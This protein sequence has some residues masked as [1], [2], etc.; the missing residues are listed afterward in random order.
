MWPARDVGRLA[1]S[2]T[3]LLVLSGPIL[4]PPV[5]YSAMAASAGVAQAHVTALLPAAYA[6]GSLLTSVPAACFMERFGLRC[7][8]VVGAALQAVFATAQ[9][10]SE[11]LWQLVALQAALGACHGFAGTVGFI[12]FCNA[13][14]GDRPSTAIAIQFSAFGLAA[15]SKCPN[16]Q[17]PARLLCLLGAR[18]AALGSSVLPGR[19]PAPGRL[20]TAPTARASRPQSR[21]F[22]RL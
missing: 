15:W 18:L 8:F 9:V 12:A 14:F 19:G 16:W 5:L 10:A 2:C 17:C 6:V 4:V 20:A 21:R 13:W 22:P 7:S 1:A 3:L 11:Q